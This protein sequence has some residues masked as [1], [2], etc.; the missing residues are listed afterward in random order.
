MAKKTENDKEFKFRIFILKNQGN[1]V[2]NGETPSFVLETEKDNLFEAFHKDTYEKS[3]QALSKNESI[4]LNL[5]ADESQAIIV[6]GKSASIQK[7]KACHLM[8]RNNHFTK[9]LTSF[10]AAIAI[11]LMNFEG[12]DIIVF[13]KI[14]L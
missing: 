10:D 12:N 13:E 4:N 6:S 2:L 11:F 7:V 9:I 3:L 14:A 5:S 8:I 1:A